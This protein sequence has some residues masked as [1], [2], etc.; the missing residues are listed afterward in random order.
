LGNLQRKSVVKITT[1]STAVDEALGGGVESQ[2][3]CFAGAALR[4]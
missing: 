2:V 3:R 4:R 1:G